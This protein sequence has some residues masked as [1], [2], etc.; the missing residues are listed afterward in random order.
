MRGPLPY[1]L[2]DR[3][4][5]RILGPEMYD[6]MFLPGPA[7]RPRKGMC[8]CGHPK[9][10]HAA[11]SSEC[12]GTSLLGP[13]VMLGDYKGPKATVRAACPCHRFQATP[14]PLTAKRGRA[15]WPLRA[16]GWAGL[17]VATLRDAAR[18]VRAAWRRR[19][20]DP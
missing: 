14:P 2:L 1:G 13:S 16:L 17:G 10:E 4:A 5:I 15:P 3:V 20:G 8:V 6:P 12:M 19:R 11:A 18:R 9:A 7:P